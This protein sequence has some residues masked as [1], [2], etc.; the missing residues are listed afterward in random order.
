MP[1]NQENSTNLFVSEAIISQIIL[2]NLF[3]IGLRTEAME[4]FELALVFNFLNK[5][6]TEGF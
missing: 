6:V 3:K 4:L 5:F 2:R 1:K